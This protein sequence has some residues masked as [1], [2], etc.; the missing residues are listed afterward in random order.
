MEDFL[1]LSILDLQLDGAKH[2]PVDKREI[3]CYIMVGEKC[4][5][6][7]VLGSPNLSLQKP[8]QDAGGAANFDHLGELENEEERGSTSLAEL[9]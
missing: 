1:V 3:I 5:D 7:L 6:C 8:V 4:V 2:R 9:E